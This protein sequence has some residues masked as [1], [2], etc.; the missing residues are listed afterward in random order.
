M[1]KQYVSDP[2]RIT[3]IIDVVKLF[4]SF[5]EKNLIKGSDS[6]IN[7]YKTL[8]E[9]DSVIS[10]KQDVKTKSEEEREIKSSG[11]DKVYEDENILIVHPKTYEASCKYGAGTKWCT[12]SITRSYWESYWSAGVNL[13]YII[14]KVNNKKYAVAV[15]PNG[16]KEGFTET[17]KSISYDKIKSL[18]V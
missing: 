12:A 18:F 7:K 8:D 14:D 3:H 13:Y 10:S 6:D 17:D 2:E 4:N 15:H 5:V 11:V 9:I 1:C 16:Q